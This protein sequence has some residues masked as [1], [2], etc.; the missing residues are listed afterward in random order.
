MPYTGG[1]YVG[2]LA[3]YYIAKKIESDKK[4]GSVDQAISKSDIDAQLR[5]AKVNTKTGE[6]L[7]DDKMG[8]NVKKST[9]FTQ[10]EISSALN[11]ANRL[12][13]PLAK[14]TPKKTDEQIFRE[15]ETSTNGVKNI[16][17]SVRNIA[18]GN[19][20]TFDLVTVQPLAERS[21]LFD[22]AEID[23]ETLCN[24]PA[25][26]EADISLLKSISL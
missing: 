25:A 11:I 16:E 24:V 1:D 19:T 13:E 5:G 7:D 21:S 15:S 6:I 18:G 23:A 2:D 4:T 12:Y 8:L 14:S 17:N 9:Q 20:V 3:L 26:D 10:D 22:K